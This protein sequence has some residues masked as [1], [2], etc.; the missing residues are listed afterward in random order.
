MANHV[1]KAGLALSKIEKFLQFLK[2]VRSEVTKITW[3]SR[4]EIKGATIVVIIVCIF[5][6]LVIWLID[7]I[8][9]LGVEAV[10]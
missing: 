5:V 10:F 3:P 4:D 8:I 6:A 1:E 9:K 2:E 7:S